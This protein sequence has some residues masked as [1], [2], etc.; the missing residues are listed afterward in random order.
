MTHSARKWN[1][2]AILDFQFSIFNFQSLWSGTC[3]LFLLIV[4]VDTVA[5]QDAPPRSLD[6]RLK[7]ELFAEHPQIVTPTGIDVDSSGRVWAVE[8]NTHFPPEGYQGHPTDR[9]LVMSDTDGDGRADKIAVFTDGLKFTM[10]VAVRPVWSIDLASRGREPPDGAKRNAR[11]DPGVDANPGAGTDSNRIGPSGSPG[12]SVYIATRREIRVFHDDD[13]D[14]HADRSDPILHLET[15]ADYPHNGLAGFAFDALGWLHFGCGENS[16]MDYKLVGSDG[17]TLSGGGE[18]GNVYRCRLD[19]SRLERIATGFWNPHASCFDAFGRLFTV[20]NDPDSRPPC[21]LMHIIP[22]GDYGYRY[23]NG[24]KGLHPFSAW[25]GEIPGTLPMVAGTGEAPS[26]VLAYESEGFPEE[27]VGNLLATSWGDHRVDRFRLKSHGASFTSLAEPVIAGGEN[28]RP[29]GIACAPDGSLYFTDWV[30]RD[31]TLHGH[32]RVWKISP[33]RSPS[34]KRVQVDALASTSQTDLIALLESP[35]VDVRRQ[36]A[37]RLTGSAD[38][39]TQLSSVLADRSH[40]P[41]A[42]VES[43]WAL[44]EMGQRHRD[45]ALTRFDGFSNC[46]SVAAAA[47]WLINSPQL[48]MTQSELHKL[49]ENLLAERIAGRTKQLTDGTALVAVLS[50][51]K[52]GRDDALVPLTLSV[53]D[54]FILSTMVNS[55]ARDFRPDDFARYL[56]SGSGAAPRVRIAMLLAAH[57]QNPRDESLLAVALGDHDPD[58][59]RLAVQWVAEEKLAGLRPRVEAVFNSTAVTADLFM[60][61]L[62]A[63]EM[64]DGTKPEDID[65]T[66]AARYVLPLL[67]D[68]T[69]PAAVRAQALRLVSPADP[70]LDASLWQRLLN[71]PDSL[72]VQEAVRTL[73]LAPAQTAAPLLVPF[74]ADVS[75]DKQLRADALAGLALTA[76]TEQPG[77]AARKLLAHVLLSDD[78]VLRLESLRSARRLFA[79]DPTLREALMSLVARIKRPAEGPSDAQ[80]ELADQIV[81]AMGDQKTGLGDEVLS[82]RSKPPTNKEEWL[83]QLNRGRPADPEAGRRLFYHANGPGCSKC[84]AVN[85]RG[86]RVGP[87]LS[88]IVETMNRVQLIQSILE[89]SSEIAPQ[90]VP[91]AFETIDGKVHTGLIVHENEGKTII[92]DAEGKITELKTIDI[93]LRVPQTKSVMPEKLTDQ[94]TLQEIRDLLA[95]LESLR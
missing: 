46:D 25:N 78:A 17:V 57:L 63:L 64:L 29:V 36:A 92:G 41:R 82:L 61:A 66:P 65:K 11:T 51:C 54:P 8:S 49:A 76:Q 94:M 56:N 50:R 47:G 4:I 77:G 3:C 23:R 67:K 22:G 14:D 9:V 35:R 18:G 81:L 30:K 91:W 31:Y 58:M 5:A 83:T 13:G 88:R 26:G 1:A 27:Y 44:V 59:R 33:V 74:A 19:G 79:A 86:G 6:P 16:G 32:G 7:V 73:Q 68:E 15:T 48:E 40:P 89:P 62:A 24:R 12:K 80:H 45:Y 85:G 72:L 2:S 28:F 69:R 10:S 55:L 71:G 70:E 84:H 95:F 39:R 37:R 43:L 87:D 90:F 53:D 75:H 38:G 42:R 21:R 20:D 34:K 52:L 60:A 93:V